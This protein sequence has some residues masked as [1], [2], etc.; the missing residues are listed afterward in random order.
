MRCPVCGRDAQP[1]DVFCA[2]CGHALAP[3]TCPRCSGVSRSGALFCVSCG[4]DLEDAAGA[5]APSAAPPPLATPSPWPVATAEEDLASE[6]DPGPPLWEARRAPAAGLRARTE[7]DA[8]APVVTELAPNTQLLV[9]DQS[10]HWARVSVE[11]GWS[12]W[13]DA[14]SLVDPDVVD[15][16]ATPDGGRT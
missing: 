9:L 13:V 14:R 3:P 7:P 10:D 2:S 16:G 6:E 4:A 8:A 15:I 1:G 12:G 5:E 11:S